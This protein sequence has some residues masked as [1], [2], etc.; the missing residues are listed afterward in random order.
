MA[1]LPCLERV[2]KGELTGAFSYP[3]NIRQWCRLEVTAATWKPKNATVSE[4]IMFDVA[5]S[6]P[7][8][9]FLI[10]ASWTGA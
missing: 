3:P 6:S 4:N 1:E 7:R 2:P 8:V 9:R 10:V 5:Q